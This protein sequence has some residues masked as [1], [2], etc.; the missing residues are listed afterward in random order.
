[1]LMIKNSSRNVT[2]IF[3]RNSIRKNNIYF[4]KNIFF[5][6]SIILGLHIHDT[7]QISKINRSLYFYVRHSNSRI[8]NTTSYLKNKIETEKI[9][10]NTMETHKFLKKH[11]DFR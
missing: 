4:P 3:S 1:M 6:D 8:S 7:N 9:F 10:Y 2:K 11:K 5:T